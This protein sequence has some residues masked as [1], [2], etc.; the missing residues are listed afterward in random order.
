MKIHVCLRTKTFFLVFTSEFVE[1]RTSFK[2]KTRIQ[3]L[4]FLFFHLKILMEIRVKYL[5]RVVHTHEFQ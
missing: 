5:L 2:M 1:I 3:D 4:F